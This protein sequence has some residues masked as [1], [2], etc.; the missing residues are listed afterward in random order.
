MAADGTVVAAVVVA[1]ADGI[2]AA[3]DVV[4]VADGIVAAAAVADGIVAAAVFGVAVVV[5]QLGL[6]RAPVLDVVL[7]QLQL[8][9]EFSEPFTYLYRYF[10]GD[11]SY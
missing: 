8:R 9:T 3:A 1:V 2:V 7:G 10:R 11:N 4:A 6:H 5:E